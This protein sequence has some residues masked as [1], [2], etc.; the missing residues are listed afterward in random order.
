MGAGFVLR[1]LAGMCEA[2]GSGG[3]PPPSRSEATSA[4]WATN[5]MDSRGGG[6]TPPLPGV[7]RFMTVGKHAGGMS[8]QAGGGC[9]TPPSRSEATSAM[10]ATNV[11][12]SQGGGETPPLPGFA[13][14]GLDLS[15]IRAGERM[16]QGASLHCRV[17]ILSRCGCT[18]VHPYVQMR[19]G[20]G[21]HLLS[22]PDPYRRSMG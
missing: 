6:E 19:V 13:G 18:R 4:M 1:I 14:F 17:N 10:W 11:M 7:A 20:D 9:E 8:L 5:A 3:V 16:H 2:F 12:D 15:R 22:V 21:L